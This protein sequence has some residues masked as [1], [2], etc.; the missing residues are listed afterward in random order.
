MIRQMLRLAVAAARV[1]VTQLVERLRPAPQVEPPPP[2]IAPSQ[3]SSS[4]Y[5]V[6]VLASVE[7]PFCGAEKAVGAYMCKACMVQRPAPCAS[8]EREVKR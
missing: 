7:C 2:T 6:R 4:A 8:E 1:E 3:W 5:H